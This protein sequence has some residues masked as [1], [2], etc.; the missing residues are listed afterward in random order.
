MWSSAAAPIIIPSM[1]LPPVRRRASRPLGLICGL[2]GALCA[3]LPATAVA[4]SC[5]E[6]WPFWIVEGDTFSAER[7][8]PADVE[9]W[10]WLPCGERP[11][12][13]TLTASADVVPLSVTPVGECAYS[14]E[15]GGVSRTFFL[16]ER[17]LMENETYELICDR[18]SLGRL[19]VGE[20]AAA[21]PPVLRSERSRITRDDP[22]SC[23]SQ[24]D[25]ELTLVVDG[26][27]QTFFAQGGRIDM[28]G[29]GDMIGSLTDR[30]ERSEVRLRVFDEVRFEVVAADGASSSYVLLADD[31]RLE[32][33]YT[34]CTVGGRVNV[35][36]S[37][38]LPWAW[39]VVTGRQRRRR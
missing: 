25:L 3:L 30:E 1:D 2:A 16:P 29:D 4:H 17:L 22:T 26:D 7:E 37:L 28:F 36:L 10:A 11:Q 14:S 33:A 15:P 9:P 35:P 13:C 39:L 31:V 38:L 8:V 34:P 27:A 19:R 6:D 32:A 5:S 21:D 24:D 12:V 20:E 18:E 23:C